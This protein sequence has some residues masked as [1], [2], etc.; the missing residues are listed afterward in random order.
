M[1]VILNFPI[2][3][4]L[5]RRAKKSSNSVSM[6]MRKNDWGAEASEIRDP[7][8]AQLFELARAAL[9]A[10]QAGSKTQKAE[11]EKYVFPALIQIQPRNIS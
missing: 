11:I 3:P 8:P 4:R 9:M 7:S 10:H 1:A 2:A 6:R 5:K